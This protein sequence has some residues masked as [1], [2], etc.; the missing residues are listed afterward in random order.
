ML[1]S[2]GGGGG[3][4]G[5]NVSGAISVSKD[6]SGAVAVGIGGFGGGGG[7]AAAVT[8]TVSGSMQTLGVKSTGV[9]AQSVGG[10]GGNGGLNVSGSLGIAQNTGIAA[11]AGVGGFGGGGGDAGA[12]TLVRD[13]ATATSGADSTAILA[14]SIGGGG[15][16][17]GLNVAG[18]ISGTS[19]GNAFSAALG[20]GGFGGG[21][22]NAGDVDVSV[23][24]DVHATGVAVDH[25]VTEDGIE[26][27][28]RDGGSSGILAQSIGGSGG[29]GGLNV[30]GGI[31]IASPGSGQSNALTLGVG[32]FGG[33]GGDAG[34]VALDVD[35][36]SVRSA[37]D[38]RFAI[39]AQ[40]IGGGGGN[41][42]INVSGGVVMDGQLTAGV[43]GFGG[44]GGIGGD[45]DA[46]ATTDIAASGAGAIGFLAQSIGGGG[47]NG[48]LNVSGGL[49][50][51]QQSST[52]T[53]V[54]GLGGFGGAGNVSGRV[55][56]TQRGVI[57]VD[58]A[59][60]IGVLAQ[61]VA[62]GGG[63]GGLNVAG[64][65]ALGK[66]YAAAI[67]IGGNGGAGADAGDV[68]LVSDG[69]IRVD[70]REAT[71]D[72]AASDEDRATLDRL[73][74]ANGILVQSIGGGGGA[75]GLNVAGV[76][77]PSGSPLVAG[78][79]G[80]GAGGGDGGAVRVERGL[81]EASVLLTL[82]NGANALTAQ[83]IGG[84]GGDAG[85]NFV[86]EAAGLTSGSGSN[87]QE[88]RLTIGGAGGDPGHGGTVDVVHV[89]DI[90]TDGR[91][92]DGLLAQ[93]VGGGGGNANI[94]FGKGL[95]RNVS[96][97]NLTVGGA[98]GDGGNGGAVSVDHSG[99]I[100]TA[101]DDATAIFAQSVGGGGGNA[102]VDSELP[103]YFLTAGEIAADVLS[104]DEKSHT[105]DLTLGRAGGTG[106]TGGD[107]T[108]AAE[109]AIETLGGRS[110][111]IRAQSVGNGGGVS[112]TSSLEY[113]GK[114]DV[115]LQIGLEGGVGGR[116]GNVAVTAAGSISTFGA[117]AHAIHAQSVGGGGGVGGAVTSS[118]Y[119][120]GTTITGA[121]GG[122]GGTGGVAGAVEVTSV[123]DLVTRG[124]GA[125][126]IHAQS[127]GGGGGDGGYAGVTEDDAYAGAVDLIK[128][129]LSG[130]GDEAAT[131]VS[132]LVGGAGGTG[133]TGAAVS[134][135][136]GGTIVT[137]GRGAHAVNAQSIG[138]GGGTG[139]MVMHGAIAGG[140]SS[141]SLAVNIGGAGGDGST[142]GDVTIRN[143]GA[144][145]TAGDESVGLRAQSVGGGGGDAG[146]LASLSI[147]PIGASSPSNSLVVNV[148]GNGG[149]GGAG[150]DVAVT[151][152]AG[153]DI[154]TTGTAAHGVFAQSLGGGGGNGSSVVALNVGTTEG[155][156][157]V[158][159]NVGGQG[160]SGG[161]AGAV[162]VTNDGHIETRGDGAHGVF[163]QS[164]GGGGGNGGLVIAANAVLAAPGSTVSPLVTVGGEGGDGNGAGD[165]TVTN[166][167]TIVTRGA[168][169][170]GILAQSIGGGGGSYGLN[171]DVRDAATA[172]DD[173]VRVEGRLGGQR[174]R[175][176]AGGHI[177][178]A[179]D[180]DLVTEGANTP[181]LMMQSI[182]GGG[183]R[184]SVH[185]RSESGVFGASSFTLG[186]TDGSNEAGLGIT[187]AQSGS[188]ATA[189]A[190]SHGALLQS[191]GGG[192]GVLSFIIEDGSASTAPVTTSARPATAQAIV[193]AAAA[194]NAP[195]T[196]ALGGD[197]GNGLDGGDVQLGLAGDVATHG[198]SAVGL[199]FQAIGAGGGVASVLGT[200]TLDVTLGATGGA[201][202]DGGALDV[203]ATGNVTTGGRRAHGVLLQSIG[204]GGGV[205]FTDLDA[206]V[207]Q[208][209]AD[210][211]GDGG[212]I[213][214]AQVGDIVTQGEGAHGLIAQSLGGGGGFV[215]GAFA[216]SAGGD[217]AGGAIALAIDGN[218]AASGAGSTALYAQSAG[219][220][221][222][223][224]IEA[225]LSAGHQIIGGE[226]GVAVA[227]DGGAVN[228]FGNAGSVMTLSG[229]DGFAFT[230]GDGGDSIVNDGLVL[231]NVTLG[232]GANAFANRAG[233]TFYSGT[234]L[235]LGDAGNLFTNDGV[236]APGAADLALVT[237]LGGSFRQGADA[238]SIFE[239]D[240]ASDTIDSLFAS[241]TA[242][243]DGAV[244]VSLLNVHRIRPGSHVK[245]LYS[246]AGGLTNEGLTL[247][248]QPSIVI[249]YRLLTDA[250]TAA[251]GYEVDFS[252]DGLI[253][254]RIAIGDYFNRVQEAGSSPALADTITALVLTTDL[255]VY[256]SYM[257]QLGPEFY[258]EQQ[259]LTLGSAQRFS[260]ALQAC[261]AP[262]L[263]RSSGD[264]ADCM[265]A[266]FDVDS[267]SHD[268]REGF[269]ATE[270]IA[271][272]YS[273]GA[274][275]ALEGDWLV[276]FGMNIGNDGSKG[277]DGRWVSD[278]TLAQLGA[279]ARRRIGASTA[280]LRFT[281][282]FAD[283]DV[284][285]RLNVTGPV[286]ASG[287]HDLRFATLVGDVS[288]TIQSQGFS[289]T[290][291]LDVGASLL[292]G[293][294]MSERG[295]GAQGVTLERA[296]GRHL[297]VEPSIAF[298]YE[299]GFEGR[300][301][302]RLY[303][304]FGVL[305]YLIGG[306]TEVR[307]GLTGAPAGV[308]PMRVISDLDQTHLTL[309]GGLELA[310]LDRYTLGLSFSAQDSQSRDS[311]TVTA[312]V[313]VPIN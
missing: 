5:L 164:I 271:R 120:T 285:R 277:Y 200:A 116:A 282:G 128:D 90:G 104:D 109:G 37:G 36:G 274:Q 60:S 240:F 182:G 71:V 11:S 181:G 153:G 178:S 190:A 103:G 139:G 283:H 198:D 38:Q 26:R 130:G 44:A 197:G 195:V 243:L 221:G 288:N 46:S 273:V 19:N 74:R 183:G 295:A 300:R 215:D 279:L 8:G 80:S 152:A 230:G 146:L 223:G 290:R 62:G 254:N 107:V 165:V 162:G 25:Y 43:G 112:G 180:G 169:A 97:F 93:S 157:L 3:N 225:S 16:N 148:G 6:A 232:G 39:G 73:E 310:A 228:Q 173:L 213:H 297:W 291:S 233:G 276:G 234:T 168:D 34:N 114:A 143:V 294:A 126:G 186:G 309:E 53:L 1:Q 235:D 144:I 229:I 125:H 68:S 29:N 286:T 284:R 17:G 75:G 261:G 113:A 216:G 304:R 179:H 45:V 88:V 156:V 123:A 227:F 312:R 191:I 140:T 246:G 302:L 119:Q 226:N 239:L 219:R 22:G 55:D 160:G 262:R 259:A 202:G 131:T 108:V 129:T 184:A 59:R 117:A 91:G 27:R 281:A 189:G 76:L 12:V 218:L 175:D 7:D 196:V 280:G 166:R 303:A 72:D 121:V 65:L 289:I 211:V 67:G 208:V 118:L 172:A 32:G 270:Q 313:S 95:N 142:G 253:G 161:H 122:T 96:G 158:G 56:A 252:P 210:N 127:I 293:D 201:S 50:G 307:A 14:Q 167:G 264:D 106:G 28:V 260:R 170:H 299:K 66:G 249:D 256:S 42:G 58:G 23:T 70:G 301:L 305:Q 63:S 40:S 13:G 251:L 212:S 151:N 176:N 269:P 94:N 222:G 265:W 124:D 248:A 278:S 145:A 52:L 199:I 33:S 78:V 51:D 48:A 105:V 159:V 275:R 147:S 192:G 89:G 102:E 250:T 267:S 203:T 188:I 272:R 81:N 64:N 150:G 69:A 86:V 255:G 209:S 141:N 205:V 41:G 2:L 237:Q 77:S 115:S 138:G 217:G 137:L 132:A 231:G 21:G 298:G 155:S 92:S 214:Y 154:L 292:E 30:S 79:G 268:S 241:G 247:T 24:G 49:Q 311:G 61:S 20:L 83:S 204:G 177:D 47:G 258:A 224:N 244:D 266:R 206:P 193:A 110:V 171:L 9:L 31:A 98:P 149:T 18:A 296:S 87:N 82:G 35:A 238:Q 263:G 15:G 4:G 111:G 236:L 242:T 207:V 84:G 99:N 85:M 101:G 287:E 163:A 185:V 100:A 257:T 306:D 54:F 136:N 220:D 135:D 133:A 308:A 57:D 134:V 10:G 194:A 187:H 174:G 245:T